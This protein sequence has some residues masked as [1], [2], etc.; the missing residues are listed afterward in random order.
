VYLLTGD[1]AQRTAVKTGLE[2]PD[3]VEILEG[4]TEGQTVLT[5]SVYGLGDKAK[6]GKPGAAD[7]TEKPGKP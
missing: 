5:S 2:K 4:V 1:I 3:A 7:T 6:L